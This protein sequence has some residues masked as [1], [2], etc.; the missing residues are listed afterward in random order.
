MKFI[1]KLLY[2]L[3]S[4]TIFTAYKVENAFATIKVTLTASTK[5]T[6]AQCATYPGLLTV[7][8]E[9]GKTT[10]FTICDEGEYLVSCAGVMAATASAAL[11]AS[12]CATV[13]SATCLAC[14]DGGT[15][16]HSVKY[17]V[18]KA[19][20]TVCSDDSLVDDCG[21]NWQGIDGKNGIYLQ[22]YTISLDADDTISA[23]VLT[24]CHLP[25]GTATTDG[26]GT[27]TSAIDC[28]YE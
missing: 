18:K 3:V 10:N 1:S 14:P 13:N 21:V 24:N 8:D 27:Y 5:A 12:V 25:S 19:T 6:S 7:R 9:C 22:T 16:D 15:V 20:I 2:S 17:K 26:T 11:L 28:D 4:F 23:N